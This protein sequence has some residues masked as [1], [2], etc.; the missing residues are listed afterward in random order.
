MNSEKNYTIESVDK[1]LL[2]FKN[3]FQN[4]SL[5]RIQPEALQSILKNSTEIANA[6]E[7]ELNRRHNISVAKEIGNADIETS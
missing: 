6:V 5:D 1:A 3:T 4:T 2:K 7:E